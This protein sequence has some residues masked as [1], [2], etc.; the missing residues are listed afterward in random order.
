MAGFLAL[1]ISDTYIGTYTASQEVENGAFVEF[2]HN[3]KTGSLAGEGATD[4]YFVVNEID[5]PESQGINTIDYRIA[6]GEFLRAHKPQSGEILATTVIEDGLVEGDT[7]GIVGDGK[8]GKVAENAPYVVQEI[9]G[10][11][12]IPT[13]RLLVL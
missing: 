7:V 8:V 3:T 13:A 5:V 6:E 12:G 9:T 1:A 10:E 4:V 2:D 11:Y